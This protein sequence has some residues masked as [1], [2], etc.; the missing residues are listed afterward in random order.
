MSNQ[1]TLLARQPIYDKQLKIYAYE[2]LFRPAGTDDSKTADGDSATSKV[3][4]NAFSEVGIH[5]L[6]ANNK[7]FI[8]FTRK[9]IISPPPFSPEDIVIEVLEDI[10]PEPQVLDGLQTLRQQGFTIALD[11]FVYKE[12][13]QP[14]INLADIIKIDVL[15]LTESELHQQVEILSRCPVKL[16]AEKVETQE[17]F[18]RCKNMGFD[19]FQG[20]FLSKP[21]L[22]RGR[23]TPAN[24][25][26]VM[27]LISDLQSPKS[28]NPQTLHDTISRDP[29]LSYKLLRL[30]NSA[31]YHLPNKIESLY[32]AILLIGSDHI[33]HW[34]SLLALSNLDDKPHAL[35]EQTMLRAKM[36]EFLGEKI[37]PEKKDLFFTVGM[38][39]MMD[40][41]FDAPLEELLTSIS[42]A[43]EI[44]TALL[45]QEG[46]LGFVLK[47]SLAYEQGN[48]GQI[49]WRGLAEHGLSIADVKAAY[50]DSLRWSMDSD[51]A[52]VLD[53]DD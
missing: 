52:V 17:M 34:A 22:V 8:N 21:M 19:Y 36:C 6:V 26:V 25:I 12:S 13:L 42:L 23:V 32:R 39:S 37:K 20:Y 10:A 1:E 53:A 5:N 11:D 38:F 40:A 4:L 48:W 24:K 18:N 16:L 45:R 47:A 44:T 41:F 30:I 50:L 33:K 51:G 35:R 28:S 49:D 2:L 46:V 27:Q 31:A 43:D 9:L 7:A 15:A 29:S 14:L 3:M